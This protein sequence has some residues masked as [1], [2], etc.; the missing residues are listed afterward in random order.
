MIPPFDKRGNL[1]PG[2]HRATWKE[3]NRRFGGNLHRE[4]LLSGLYSALENLQNAGC[5]TVYIDGSFVTTKEKPS[6][7][8]GC[9]DIDNVSLD[10]LDPVLMDFTKRQA[11]QKKKYRGELFPN[12]PVVKGETAF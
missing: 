12:L 1:P 3:I 7:F 9:W 2:I 6:D 11:A 8:D 4:A 10:L 5:E